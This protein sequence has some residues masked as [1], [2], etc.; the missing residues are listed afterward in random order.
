MRGLK[1]LQVSC[2]RS[3]CGLFWYVARTSHQVST[4]AAYSGMSTFVAL[5][6]APRR[7]VE[8]A[9]G[10]LG[11]APCMH[12]RLCRLATKPGEKCGL[13]FSQQLL[14]FQQLQMTEAPILQ[15]SICCNCLIYKYLNLSSILGFDGFCWVVLG[16]RGQSF[17]QSDC[18][19]S[20]KSGTTSG[21][22]WSRTDCYFPIVKRVPVSL[23]KLR[24]VLDA[25]PALRR[26]N[27]VTYPPPSAICGN[28]IGEGAL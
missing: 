18:E 14:F 24:V 13:A 15:S 4:A 10:A 2:I 23:K 9:C 12:A 8:Y 3:R 25:P 19:V 27:C 1:T 22:V 26:T 7:T 16:A 21:Y 28:T 11:R 6:R 5:P 20:V 17:R